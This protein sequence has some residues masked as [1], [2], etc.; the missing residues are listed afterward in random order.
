MSIAIANTDKAIV[1]LQAG[2]GA[3]PALMA[4]AAQVVM[5]ESD[6]ARLPE[7]YPLFA[8]LNETLG[9][10]LHHM[11]PLDG[12]TGEANDVWCLA[13]P[14]QTYAVATMQGGSFELDLSAAPGDYRMQWINGT[15]GEVTAGKPQSVAG[16][17]I[18][19]VTAPSDEP[20]LMLLIKQ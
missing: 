11:N 9:D 13:E 18:I 14:Q 16:G 20:W 6:R 12:V 4:G 1:C 8:P 3:L 17:H 7:V 10:K 5:N 15:S 2:T 19:T